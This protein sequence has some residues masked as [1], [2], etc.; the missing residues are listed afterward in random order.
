MSESPV[1]KEESAAQRSARLRREKRNAR[2]ASEGSDRLAK[3][4][5]LSGR[6]APAPEDVSLVKDK[7]ASVAPD[8]DEI[9]ISEHHYTPRITPRPSG[10][11]TPSQ[12]LSQNPFGPMPPFGAGG[13]GGSGPQDDMAADPMMRMMQQMMSGMGGGGEPSAGGFP[14]MMGDPNDANNPMNDLPPFMKNLMNAQQQ[15]QQDAAAAQS[16]PRGTS[17]YLWRIVHAVFAVLLAGYIALAGPFNGSKLSRS[18]S[19]LAHNSYSGPNL[20]YLFATVELVLQTSR[21]FLEKGR[22][23][24]GGML[25]TIA[26]SGLVPEPWGGYIRVFGR[27]SVIWQTVVG[28]AMTVVFVLGAAAWW[29]GLAAA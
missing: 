3:I 25:A 4:T 14:P 29:R 12:Q 8:P 21:Y 23:Q 5:Q 24:G 16:A 20:F 1:P 28:D 17:A 6:P 19:M 18:E 2:I 13:P 27:Y 22:L 11:S 7:Q 15:T 10:P 9:D 26:N